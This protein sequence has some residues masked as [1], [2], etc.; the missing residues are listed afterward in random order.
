MLLSDEEESICT[1]SEIGN[2]DPK[3]AQL[4]GKK[5]D[6]MQLRDCNDK[7]EPKHTWSSTD[8]VESKLSMP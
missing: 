8:R 3:R 1:E 2:A 6:A 5:V 4:K 7:E